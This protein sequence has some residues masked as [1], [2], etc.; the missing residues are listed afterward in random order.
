MTGNS[1]SSTTI[2]TFYK[3]SSCT[4][5]Q[6]FIH[7]LCI[8]TFNIFCPA[9][10]ENPPFSPSITVAVMFTFSFGSA[11]AA[12]T[13]G[14]AKA[15]FDEAMKNVK[16]VAETIELTY[17]E[18]VAGYD[19]SYDVLNA[20]YDEL[21]DVAV[22]YHKA[23]DAYV[24]NAATLKAA[25]VYVTAAVAPAEG[26]KVNEELVMK[27]VDE[28][29]AADKTEALNIINA[30]SV[31]DYST[32]EMPKSVTDRL[33]SD[34]NCTTYQE[35]VKELIDKAVEKINEKT[36]DDS[37]D[38]SDYVNALA[39]IYGSADKAAII[40]KGVK[41]PAATTLVAEEVYQSGK[42]SSGN[43]VYTGT[44]TYK[45]N[46][47]YIVAEAT[48]GSAAILLKN[49]KTAAVAGQDAI[50]AANIAA[51]KAAIASAYAEYLAEE[52]ADKSKA[53]DVKTMLDFLADES[54]ITASDVSVNLFKNA[55]K[56]AVANA[57]SDVTKLKAEAAKLA[58]EKDAN[59]ALV[60]DAKDVEDEV[61]KG[62][63]ALYKAAV[64][65]GSPA[66]RYETYV[67]NINDLYVSLDDAKLAYMKK[68]RETKVA[69]LLAAF[70]ENETYYP[71]E[72]AK[73]KALTEEYLAKVN[74]VTELSKVGDYDKTYFGTGKALF[75][76]P[77]DADN[78]GV[79]VAGGKLA[80]ILT[81]K[82]VDVKT[83]ASDLKGVAKDYVTFL[84]KSI[85]KADNKYYV[86]EN[87]EKLEAELLKLVGNTE[88]RTA[89]EIN[90]LSEQVI[91]MVK[92]L[93][94]K[95]AVDAAKEAAD[96]AIDALPSK[97][98]TT[99]DKAAIDA[100]K[101][102]VD[103][104]EEI[105]ASDYNDATGNKN[106]TLTNAITSYAYAYRNEMVAKVKAVSSTDKA[107]IEALVDEIEAFV[108]TY[109]NKGVFYE[110]GKLSGDLKDLET[111]LDNIKKA[112][113]DEVTKAIAAI[114]V[115][116]NITDADKATVENARKLYDAYVAEYTDYKDYDYDYNVSSLTDGF[117]A[118]DFTF[119]ALFNAETLLGLNNSPAKDVEA[120]KITARST[121]K[122]G[123]ITVKWTVKGEA[124]IDGY[125]IWKSTKANK[126]YKKA[127][128]TTK[129]TY[130][131]TKGL[132]KGTRYYYKVRAYKV[133]DGKNVYSDWSNKANRKAK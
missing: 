43:P 81:A 75:E 56:T 87:D 24:T 45:L 93:P 12:T 128:T 100:A 129:K 26:E 105:S 78:T 90:A 89:K 108:D 27:L 116:S 98:I 59:G 53:A 64:I 34:D 67:D 22:E 125:Q 120:L 3:N 115:G 54:E 101:A 109:G 18:A 95:A 8:K 32:A 1:R 4:L 35:H 40:E 58:A 38:I 123:S 65:P 91:A 71:T 110:N 2:F 79:V 23:T 42:D 10:L 21:F 55:D 48:S 39:V 73:V 124:D 94:T 19:V 11:M 37:S 127:F 121:A 103:A 30:L 111:Y 106:A 117:V 46:D 62:T 122:K 119:T 36:F 33:A 44:G 31:T 61:T 41:N 29:Y 131:N 28:Q 63:V 17:D 25:L 16:D 60:R 57:L 107:A 132:K 102:A 80:D 85:K 130:K 69:E 9:P 66:A 118:D 13:D 50:D 104:Y 92:T 113:A 6:P 99:A 77:E 88:A 52:N 74:A 97:K 82:Q 96:D 86:G 47:N 15:Y 126:G 7:Q 68:V 14:V 83:L 112:A 70:E 76:V 20:H 72:L 133:V 49:F 114:P 51:T 5:K 84:N